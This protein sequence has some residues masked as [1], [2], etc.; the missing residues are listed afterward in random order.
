MRTSPTKRQASTALATTA[1]PVVAPVTQSAE[2]ELDGRAFNLK[3]SAGLGRRIEKS[4][5]LTLADDGRPKRRGFTTCGGI[6]TRNARDMQ[7]T[8]R[9]RLAGSGSRNVARTADGRG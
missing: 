6:R 8:T 1:K 2:L 3:P 9:S 5:G 4:Y 7:S